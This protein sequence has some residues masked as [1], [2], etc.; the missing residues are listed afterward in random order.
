MPARSL[1]QSDKF[2]PA[3]SCLSQVR[4]LHVTSAE[5]L[6]PDFMKY[7]SAEV[8]THVSSL[9]LFITVSLISF[10]LF[11]LPR[12]NPSPPVELPRLS[13]YKIDLH[14]LVSEGD[15]FP[16]ELPRVA[17]ELF[18]NMR[19]GRPWE[20]ME[21]VCRVRLGRPNLTWVANL[22]LSSATLFFFLLLIVFLMVFLSCFHVYVL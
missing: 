15:G 12:T 5:W 10:S 7:E 3:G 8:L 14:L 20:G 19:M 9:L 4:G 2:S 1:R 6:A 21:P 13:L 18:R 22:I 17:A 16:S 11:P